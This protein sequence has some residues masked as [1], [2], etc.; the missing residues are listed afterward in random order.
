MSPA[1][2]AIL[3]S[4]DTKLTP[5]WEAEIERSLRKIES[6]EATFLSAEELF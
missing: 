5:G 6:G 1:A 3:E 4:A 2:K